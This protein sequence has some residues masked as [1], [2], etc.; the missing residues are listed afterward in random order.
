MKTYKFE[1]VVTALSSISHNGGEISGNMSR[2]RREKFVQP[3]GKIAEVPIISGNAIRGILRDVGMYHMLSSLGYGIA[4]D[5][6]VIG[7]PLKAFYFLFSGGSLTSTNSEK[8]NIEAFRKM[9]TMIPLVSLFG[10]AVGNSIIP[11]KMDCGKMYP[12]AKE[13]AHLV[14]EKFLTDNLLSVWDLCQVETYT[15]RD[16]AKNDRLLHMLQQKQLVANTLF[17]EDEIQE[18]STRQQM[19]Y[20][21]ETI[22]AG[23]RFYWQ[24]VLRD[25]TDIELDAFLTALIYFG[26]TPTVGGKSATGLGQVKIHFDKWIEIDSHAHV[27]GTEVNMR[28]LDKYN[29]HLKEH[30]DE[31]KKIILELANE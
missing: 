30:S 12:I 20:N 17:Q 21:V 28:L 4:Q 22:V 7:L 6:K 27:K 15:R 24:V 9:K 23:T 19:I 18:V 16:D 5:G 29:N 11:G 10:G 14:P 26:K 3:D 13:T 25:I 2:L 1:G 8:V 31:I